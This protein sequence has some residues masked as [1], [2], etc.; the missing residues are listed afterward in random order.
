MRFCI[1]DYLNQL[2]RISDEMEGMNLKFKDKILD[3]NYT[4]LLK[5][6]EYDSSKIMLLILTLR[7]FF[8]IVFS[9]IYLFYNNKGKLTRSNYI[10]IVGFI[11]EIILAVISHIH[12]N[13][14]KMIMYI[15]YLRFITTYINNA[16][17][18]MFPEN[19]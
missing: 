13:N 18:L 1:K 10:L 19:Y 7:Y 3:E 11:V 9:F 12:N 17:V 4:E 2:L 16:I 8:S 14:L 6:S 15:K 5:N